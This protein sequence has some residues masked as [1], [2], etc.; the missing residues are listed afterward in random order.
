MLIRTIEYL[1]DDELEIWCA[2]DEVDV[3]WAHWMPVKELK[4]LPGEHPQPAQP[5]DCDMR[6]GQP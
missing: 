3:G 5:A 4:H 2:D 1:R 6:Y